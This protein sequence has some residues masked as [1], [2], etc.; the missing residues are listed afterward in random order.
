MHGFSTRKSIPCDGVNCHVVH[1]IIAR[2]GLPD[3]V[4]RSAVT[5]RLFESP[6]V[7]TDLPEPWHPI[8]ATLTGRSRICLVK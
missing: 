7:I 8:C 4:P 1:S 5:L 3:R 2:C 6:T